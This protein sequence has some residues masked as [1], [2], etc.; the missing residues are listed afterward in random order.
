MTRNISLA[1]FLVLV[2]AAFALGSSFEA[3]EWYYLKVVGPSWTPPGWLFGPV[4]AVFYVLMAM[5]AWETWESGHTDRLK[6]MIWWGL[7]LV[8]LPGWS[9]LFFGMHRPGWAWAELSIA[10]AVAVLCMSTFFR[11][12]RQG[13]YLLA[14]CLAWLLFFWALQFLTWNMS[15]GPID[16][17]L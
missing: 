14:P 15:G 10:L 13:A 1:V 16:R 11:I 4:W 5:A 6:A 9:A 8:L 2:T 3:G 17:Y 12:S 7:L